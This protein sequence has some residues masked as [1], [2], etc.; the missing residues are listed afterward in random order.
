MAE[1]QVYLDEVVLVGHSRGGEGVDRASLQIPLSA[2][3][4]GCQTAPYVP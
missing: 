2:P 4:F 3:D 1:H